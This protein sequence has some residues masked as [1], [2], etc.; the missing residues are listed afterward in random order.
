MKGKG[1][2]IAKTL[3]K[4]NRDGGVTLPDFKIYYKVTVIKM[5]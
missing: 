4:K 3:L 2:R 1:A 5:V